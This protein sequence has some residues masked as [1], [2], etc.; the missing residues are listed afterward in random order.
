MPRVAFVHWASCDF[1][2]TQPMELSFLQLVFV[3]TRVRDLSYMVLR[4]FSC[5]NKDMCATPGLG[6]LYVVL[7]NGVPFSVLCAKVRLALSPAFC[8]S[9]CS[10][11]VRR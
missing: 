8:T 1:E 9:V 3:G 7:G 10:L 5:K 4:R 6:W 2:G 11:R